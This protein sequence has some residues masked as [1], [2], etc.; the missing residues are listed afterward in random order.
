LL[1]AAGQGSSAEHALISLLAL[2]GHRLEPLCLAARQ[3]SGRAPV[4]SDPIDTGRSRTAIPG[5]T[6]T[7]LLAGQ[8]VSLTVRAAL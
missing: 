1:V 8:H 2:N 3:L 7:D 4:A 5:Q 6:R